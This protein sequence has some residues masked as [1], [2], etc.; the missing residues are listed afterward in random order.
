MIGCRALDKRITRCQLVY[1]KRNTPITQSLPRMRDTEAEK[2]EESV[3]CVAASTKTQQKLPL[4]TLN[5]WDTKF[6][7]LT[8]LSPISY[9]PLILEIWNRNVET[10]ARVIPSD[11]NSLFAIHLTAFPFDRQLRLILA[12]SGCL[13]HGFIGV[14]CIEWQCNRVINE[15]GS[16]GDLVSS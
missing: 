6:V 8:S 13:Q 9:E 4:Y 3:L 11:S 10:R 15:F 12:L 2:E 14:A 7:K 1:W 5:K 16:I